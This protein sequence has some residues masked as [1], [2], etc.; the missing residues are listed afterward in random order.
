MTLDQQSAA[1]SPTLEPA[2][3]VFPRQ[4]LKQAIDDGVIRSGEPV[5]AENI[6][7]ASLDL[8]LGSRA[9]RL[10]SSFL[11]GKAGVEE[12]LKRLQLGPSFSIK[13]GAILEQ[14]RPYLIPLQEA[15]H[16]PE[17]TRARTNPKSS[18]GRV[19][20]FT[21]VITDHSSGF[22]EISPGYSGKL[23]LEVFTRSFTI[24]VKEGLS[25]NQLR[26]APAGPVPP[27]Q[28]REVHRITPL[29]YTNGEALGDDRLVVSDSAISL[30]VDLGAEKDQPI[31]F[32]ARKYAGLLDLTRRDHDPG[33][34][35][36]PVWY[37]EG[38]LILDQES[39]YLLKSRE[40]V[41]I[42]ATHAAEMVPFDPTS[43]EL[44][45]HYAGF[46][47]PGFGEPSE[48][49]VPGTTAV[50]EVR[51]HDVPF[52]IEGG[53]QICKLTFEPMSEPPDT[54]YGAAIGSHYQGAA[55]QRML[56]KYF[57]EFQGR[58]RSLYDA[59]AFLG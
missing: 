54:L 5:P 31:G 2:A 59:A 14:N 37:D 4:R 53:Q 29:L 11:P 38:Q 19:D 55:Q 10:I 23:W 46:F 35:W 32:K 33:E 48:G 3:G 15:L 6:Q 25:L 21:R 7:P 26:L 17:D 24:K 13:D 36:E 40:R 49:G 52:A 9:Y 1:P 42:P 34:F 51:A 39:F 28:P 43:G 56:S 45:T 47:D 57:T 44:R 22:D 30:T 58:Q 50:L 27:V 16:L 8:R 12:K 20:V 18:T 41:H